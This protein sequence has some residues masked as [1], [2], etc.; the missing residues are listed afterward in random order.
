MKVVYPGSFDP[1]TLGHINIINKL[2]SNPDID[3]ILI[4][5]A[6][7][8]KKN[9]LIELND[10]MNL[11]KD[12][13]NS[14]KITVN[15][16]NGTVVDYCKD[17]NISTIIRGLRN[18]S[19]FSS[20]QELNYIN[21]GLSKDVLTLLVFSDKEYLEVSSSLV[22]EYISFNKDVKELVPTNVYEYLIKEKNVFNK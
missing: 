10:R 22:K 11:I 3:H 13:F 16:T 20:E 21:Q 5:V 8:I 4:L 14:D 18:V 17:N 7:N 9:N 1:L 2:I 15:T 6:N 19:D 12:S